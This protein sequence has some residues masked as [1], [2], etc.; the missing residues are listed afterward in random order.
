MRIFLSLSISL[1]T[2]LVYLFMLQVDFDE[3]SPNEHLQI[4]CDVL[5]EYDGNMKLKLSSRD[6]ISDRIVQFLQIHKYDC[7]QFYDDDKPVDLIDGIRQ[8]K[9][10]TI[11]P[12]LHWILSNHE[13]LTKRSYLSSF[14]MPIDVPVDFLDE[15]NNPSL[16]ELVNTYKE[17]QLEF[18]EVHKE[19]EATSSTGRRPLSD[20]LQNTKQLKAIKQNLLKK[21]EH[22]KAQK[23]LNETFQHVLEIA[24]KIRQA[25]E[26][27]IRLEEQKGEQIQSMAIANRRLKQVRIVYDIL[28]NVVTNEEMPIEEVLTRLEEESNRSV[29]QQE[30]ELISQRQELELKLQQTQ[31]ELAGFIHTDVDLEQL[32]NLVDELDD[33]LLSK[34]RELES[35]NSDGIVL[36]R[37]AAFK[38]VGDF[39]VNADSQVA[40][41]LWRKDA[42]TPFTATVNSYCQST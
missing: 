8:G 31:K 11:Y 33:E 23:R 30:M 1:S 28:M 5:Q 6:Q 7:I 12:I 19:H 32:E 29:N 41:C 25:Q 17:L 22:E 10:K 26:D 38:Q 37:L 15:K 13:Y 21:V 34:R 27:E 4:L 18:V 20:I 42:D 14:L 9:K 2:K 36:N 35:I 39:A 16:E 24:N 3:K 40:Y